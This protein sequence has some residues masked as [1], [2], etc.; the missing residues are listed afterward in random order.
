MPIFIRDA[1]PSDLATIT[2]IYADSVINGIGTYELDP[3]SMD[4]MTARYQTITD[5]NFPYL[6]AVESEGG[7]VLGYAYA[8]SY[9][10]RPAYRYFTENS[11]YVASSARGKHVGKALLD[12]LIKRCTALGLRQMIAVIGGAN[13]ASVGLHEKAGF[14]HSGILKASGLKFGRWLDTVL[15]QLPLGEGAETVPSEEPKAGVN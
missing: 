7:E 4:D 14:S 9:R 13:P 8:S 6:V 2:A 3:P 1:E 15:M 5:Q 12:E 11:I 10:P